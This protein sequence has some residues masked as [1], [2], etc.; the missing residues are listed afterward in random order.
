MSLPTSSLVAALLL[1]SVFPQWPAIAQLAAGQTTLI[2]DFQDYDPGEVP[3]RWRFLSAQSREYEPL[4]SFM[5][6]DEIF[7]I[8]EEDGNRFL[9]GYTKGE[10]QRISLS[11][12]NNELDWNLKQSPVLSW[13]WRAN[14]LPEGAS[15][16]HA[17]DTGGAVYVVFK[18]DW[19]GRPVSIK[20]TYSSTLPVGTTVSFGKLKVIVASSGLDETG[21]WKQVE[22]NI[23]ED[24]LRVFGKKAP[25]QPLLIT[26]WSDSDDTRTE[27]EVDFDDIYISPGR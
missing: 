9:R 5:D 18:T 23:A 27:A 13:R 20:Y 21:S 8:V 24:Y 26:L 7:Y 11:N 15:E 2:D 10:A 4:D 1:G 19:L 16:R 12:E 25:D 3:G 17:N 22:R 14:R 6:D